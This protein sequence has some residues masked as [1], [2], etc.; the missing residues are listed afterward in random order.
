LATQEAVRIFRG[1]IKIKVMQEKSELIVE[2]FSG[3]ANGII[4]DEECCD[5]IDLL[6]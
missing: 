2:L 4:T 3:Y 5:M 6:N 1:S